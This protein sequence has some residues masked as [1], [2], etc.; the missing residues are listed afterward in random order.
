MNNDK[1]N[2]NR[3]SNSL[4]NNLE[5]IGAS[6]STLGE[7]LFSFVV[8]LALFSLENTD[9]IES[10]SEQ[11]KRLESMQMQINHVISELQEIKKILS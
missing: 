7:E 8:D 2:L 10:V 11:P 5:S 1:N 3:T 6:L 9:N 4:E